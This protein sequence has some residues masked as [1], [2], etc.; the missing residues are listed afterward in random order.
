MIISRLIHRRYR[1]AQ[2]TGLQARRPP[3]SEQY[4]W[5]QRDIKGLNSQ[6]G[7]RTRGLRLPGRSS[8]SLQLKFSTFSCFMGQLFH[9][10]NSYHYHSIISTHQSIAV[11]AFAKKEQVSTGA[12]K[13]IPVNLPF[14]ASPHN[15]REPQ[16]VFPRYTSDGCSKPVYS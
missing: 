3:G 5:Q 6:T 13:T 10:E 11:V 2:S 1:D 4:D 8:K 14:P 9:A 7:S 12:M 15:E 16:S